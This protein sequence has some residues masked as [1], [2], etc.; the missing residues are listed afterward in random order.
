MVHQG[1]TDI[2]IVA[3]NLDVLADPFSVETVGTEYVAVLIGDNNRAA[4]VPA[5][6]VDRND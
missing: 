3:G 1:N 2:S 5:T 6:V 4:V